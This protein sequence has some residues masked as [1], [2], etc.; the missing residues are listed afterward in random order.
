MGIALLTLGAV[1][2]LLR[3]QRRHFESLIAGF[4]T[5]N[6]TM[7]RQL[8]EIMLTQQKKQEAQEEAIE[9]VAGYAIK[10]RRDIN[11]LAESGTERDAD[12]DDGTASTP[13][14]TKWLN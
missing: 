9:K 11:T 4:S 8:T 12:D 2:A 13:A 6:L 14:E 7:A 5:Q 3:R 1:L 10:M